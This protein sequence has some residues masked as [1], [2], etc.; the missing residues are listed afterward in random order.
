MPGG[1]RVTIAAGLVSGALL[2]LAGIH[3]YWVL[4][5]G[6]GIRGVVPTRNDG[7]PLFVPGP[8]STLVVALALLTAAF[9]IA[10][11]VGWVEPGLAEWMPRF[12]VWGI[13]L[14]FGLR[15]VGELRYV[16]FFKKV[17]GSAFARLDTRLYSPLCAALS[18][19]A[20]WVAISAP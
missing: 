17:T 3:V 10:W 8:G 5:G 9:L 2:L 20:A 15:A 6:W 16:G 14:V 4:G 13:A 7:E 18:V 19:L 1:A 11:R 12:G